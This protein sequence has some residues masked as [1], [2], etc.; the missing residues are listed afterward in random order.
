MS[1]SSATFP[2][3]AVIGSAPDR[4]GNKKERDEL[5]KGKG[6]TRCR[7]GGE[8]ELM[9]MATFTTVSDS[10]DLARS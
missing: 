6:N 2:A 1:S 9:V 5:E 10:G 7:E 4:S 8:R 3:T